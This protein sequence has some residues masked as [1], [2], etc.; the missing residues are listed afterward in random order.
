M[1]AEMRFAQSVKGTRRT[2]LSSLGAAALIIAGLAT[3]AAPAAAQTYPTRNVTFVVGYAAG[4]TGDVVARII[5]QKLSDALGQSVVVEN[6]AGASGGLAAG[7]VARAEP[8]G[9]TI[10]VG[11]SAE[12]AINPHLMKGLSYD[13][14]NDLQPIALGVVVPLG[15]VVPAK[16]P[17]GTLEE[18]IVGAKASNQGLSY[19]SAGAGTPSHF[20]GELLRLK[21]QSK[22]THV[23][24]KGAGPAL[25]DILGGHVDL[26]FPGLPAAMP[27]VRANQMKLLA[28]SSEKRSSTALNV[29]PVA[30]VINAPGFDITL[31]VG[32]FAPRNTPKDIVARL[33]EEINKILIVPDIRER[34][35]AEGAD[36]TPMTVDQFTA[37]TKA[38]NEKYGQLAKETGLKAQ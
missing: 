8:D 9:H 12:I 26:Y 36:V 1:V 10:L 5:G 35:L 25:N 14:Q 2:F 31:W 21:T 33:N 4:G 18:L 38:E 22:M 29:P 23:P 32:F 3:L 28:V 24:Y 37:F 17:Y 11:Q 15:L 34:L 13:P 27:N 16:S 6:R 7:G 19:A 30:E 20:A